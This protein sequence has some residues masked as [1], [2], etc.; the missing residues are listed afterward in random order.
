MHAIAGGL[1][2]ELS[3][4]IAS[5]QAIRNS[6]VHLAIPKQSVFVRDHRKPRASVFLELYAGSNLHKD[7][8]EAIINLVASSISEMEPSDVS[9][10][11]QKGNLLSKIESDSGELMATKQ[12]EYTGR[13]EES[14]VARVNSILKPVLGVDNYKAEVSADIDF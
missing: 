9:I 4:T 2:G 10:V 5:V 8:V 6:R 7:Q 14:I 1:E 12:L 11:D 3:R 13:V